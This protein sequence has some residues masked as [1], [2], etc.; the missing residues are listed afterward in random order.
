M[1]SFDSAPLQLPG[2]SINPYIG[3]DGAPPIPES[4]VSAF[5]LDDRYEFG[6]LS[7]SGR[8]ISDFALSAIDNNDVISFILYASWCNTTFSDRIVRMLVSEL[9]HVPDVSAVGKAI[10]AIA[11]M[12]D[13]LQVISPNVS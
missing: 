8:Y 12:P 4:I 6:H 2:T 13:V 5:I 9:A 7:N 10:K 1:R 3:N 11:N